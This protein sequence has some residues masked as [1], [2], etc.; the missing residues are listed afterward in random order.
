MEDLKQAEKAL[1][2]FIQQQAFQLEITSQRKGHTVKKTSSIYKL[3]PFL[4]DGILRVGGRL[5][6]MSMPE[7][8]KHQVILPKNSYLSTL[9]LDHIHQSAGH[10]G[11]R[12]SQSFTRDTG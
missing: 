9:L 7:D 12:Y 3:D 4:M 2:G 11:I 8:L 6:K 1:V 10:C 5:H